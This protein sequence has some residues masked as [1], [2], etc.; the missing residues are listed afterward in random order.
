MLLSY[1]FNGEPEYE[2]YLANQ[3]ENGGFD[4]FDEYIS[5]STSIDNIEDIRFEENSSDEDGYTEPATEF[6]VGINERLSQVLVNQDIDTA[7]LRELEDHDFQEEE[8]MLFWNEQKIDIR[9]G[10]YFKSKKDVNY[11]VR[12]WNIKNGKEIHLEESR[13]KRFKAMC[14]I[15]AHDYVSATPNTQPCNWMVFAKRSAI[16]KNN[17]SLTT[18]TLAAYIHHATIADITYPAK[19]IQAYCKETLSV[20]VTYIKAWRAR[21]KAIDN[22]YGNW[23]SNFQELPKYINA[24]KRANPRTVVEWNH[25]ADGSSS[26]FIFM[27]FGRLGHP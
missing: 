7:V 1:E 11:V 15:N 9:A 17:T 23:E 10:M 19:Q 26:S 22:I 4:G 13:P 6:Q 8:Y 3:D 14:K 20:D 18:K 24:L 12:Q 27:Y 5:E 25:Q 16:R 21:K 2:T